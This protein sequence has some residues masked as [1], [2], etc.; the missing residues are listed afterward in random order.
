MQ[1][2]VTPEYLK[3]QGFSPT[4]TERF[5]DKVYKDGPVPEHMPHLGKCWV[6]T[7]YRGPEGYGKFWARN[8]TNTMMLAHVASWILHGG[9]SPG[10]LCVCHHCDTPECVRPDHLFLGTN[11]NNSD[12]QKRKGRDSHC[13]KRGESN[14][15]SR[16]TTE[17]V[18]EIRRLY[19]AG[20]IS[21]LSLA[22]MFSVSER[23]IFFI[24]HRLHWKHI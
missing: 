21:Q 22:K 8:D 2:E 12:D 4:F 17:Q 6:W 16:L 5:W 3:E 20:G 11:K 1:I 7:A 14:G 18:L 9:Q 10:N 13:I 24:V 15:T 19:S 23:N